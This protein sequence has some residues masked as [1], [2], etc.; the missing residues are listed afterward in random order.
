[1]GVFGKRERLPMGQCEAQLPFDPSIL[2][3]D[4]VK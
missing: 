3:Y 1:M 2:A 4:R